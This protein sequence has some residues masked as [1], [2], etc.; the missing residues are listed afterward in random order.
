MCIYILY[1]FVRAG[2][3]IFSCV[4]MCIFVCACLCACMRA[5]REYLFEYE[6]VLGAK[7]SRVHIRP[8]GVTEL[9]V[10]LLHN[11]LLLPQC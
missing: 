6:C 8:F 11:S 10:L 2:V 4:F 5:P 3:R 9:I 7:L 1:A